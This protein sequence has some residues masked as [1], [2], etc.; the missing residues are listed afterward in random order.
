MIEEKGYIVR[1]TL[2]TSVEFSPIERPT[3]ITKQ[4]AINNAIGSVHADLW[5][6]LESQ[7]WSIEFHAEND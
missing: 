1:A 5:A 2:T 4:D 7:G 3:P 6:E